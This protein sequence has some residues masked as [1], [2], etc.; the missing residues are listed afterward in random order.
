MLAEEDV[1]L[2]VADLIMPCVS[3]IELA[4]QARLLCPDLPVMFV[5]G[6]DSQAK[7]AAQ[8]GRVLYK[9]VRPEEM[10]TA[11]RQYLFGAPYAD[12]PA[13]RYPLTRPRQRIH[14]VKQRK[15]RKLSSQEEPD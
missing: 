10:E 9:P 13:R 3:G 7:E 5:T 2:M 15:I 4:A 1:D 11:I 6:Y 8:V 12:A 14:V